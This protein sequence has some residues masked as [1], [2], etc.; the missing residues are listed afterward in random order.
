MASED[1]AVAPKK[2][3][4]Q[5]PVIA[6]ATRTTPSDVEAPAPAAAHGGEPAPHVS[7]NKENGLLEDDAAGCGWLER[8]APYL[9]HPSGAKQWCIFAAFWGSIIGLLAW[10]TIWALP[11]LVDNVVDPA[12]TAIEENLTKTQIGV[13][14]IAA[15]VIPPIVL[16]PHTPAEWLAALVFNFGIALLLVEIGTTLGM[17]LCFW[18]GRKFLRRPLSG[19]MQNYKHAKVRII[20]PKLLYVYIVCTYSST[21]AP[22]I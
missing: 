9:L 2:E 14:V 18:L 13:V 20:L 15:I 11:R 19:F 7:H 17:A 1:T 12:L 4:Q 22:A 10:F 16:L 6:E 8:T 21:Q 3:M 5:P